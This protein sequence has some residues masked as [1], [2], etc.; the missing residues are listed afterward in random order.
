MP[1][2]WHALFAVRDPWTLP[3]FMHDLM[4]FVAG[5]TSELLN[6]HSTAW[7]EGYYDTLVKTEKQFRFITAYIKQNPVDKGL[8]DAPEQWEA[9][10]AARRNLV[11]DPWPYFL[12]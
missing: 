2:H 11:T 5:K 10:S 12:D 9:S 4:S 6:A 1:D 8:V 3:R 7:Q